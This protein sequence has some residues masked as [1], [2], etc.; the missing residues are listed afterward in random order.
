MPP[1]VMRDVEDVPSSDRGSAK[2]RGKDLGGMVKQPKS[3]RD[4]VS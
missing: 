4:E 1:L 2:G 3:F